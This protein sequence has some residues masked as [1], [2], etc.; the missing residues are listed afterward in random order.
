MTELKEATQTRY[1]L[2]CAGGE[3]VDRSLPT[4]SWWD[5]HELEAGTYD[6][7]PLTAQYHPVKDGQTPY[8][9]RAVI[10]STL[11]ETYRVNRFFTASSSQR[12]YPNSKSTVVKVFYGFQLSDGAELAGIHAR[13]EVVD[14]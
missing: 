1:V 5:K 9:Y 4:A 10:D 3:Y 8:W 12:E 2:V 14:C 6:L 11:V 7:E 13:V